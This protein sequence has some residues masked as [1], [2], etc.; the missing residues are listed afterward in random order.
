MP[1]V[2]KFIS[3]L[4]IAEKL[5]L[6]QVRTTSSPPNND[7]NSDH[8]MKDVENSYIPDL[9][10]HDQVKYNRQELSSSPM[11]PWN[12]RMW[13]SVGVTA[14]ERIHRGWDMFFGSWG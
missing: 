3:R 2:H 12:A 1:V 9:A 7:I 5:R 14:D 6:M 11:K 8:S 4:D 10:S 13:E